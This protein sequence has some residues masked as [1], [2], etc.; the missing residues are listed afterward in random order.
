MMIRSPR[1]KGKYVT[2][3]SYAFIAPFIREG[4]SPRPTSFPRVKY[5]ENEAE[6]GL[7]VDK[8]SFFTVFLSNGQRP[9]WERVVNSFFRRYEYNLILRRRRGTKLENFNNRRARS[10]PVSKRC[11]SVR[12]YHSNHQELRRVSSSRTPAWPSQCTYAQ[13]VDEAGDSVI[14]VR[15]CNVLV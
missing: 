1:D 3:R 2:Y 7:P 10:F 11:G 4:Q 6:R 14:G 15:Q 8:S 9:S 5:V 13:M 12:R